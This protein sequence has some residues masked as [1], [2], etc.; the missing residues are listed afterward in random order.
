M[1]QS[2]SDAQ[3]NNTRARQ[4]IHDISCPYTEKGRTAMGTTIHRK[5]KLEMFF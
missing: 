1:L 3:Q 2:V 5:I 4:A